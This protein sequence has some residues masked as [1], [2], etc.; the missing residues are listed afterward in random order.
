MSVALALLC[1]DGK[2]LSLMDQQF[3]VSEQNTVEPTSGQLWRTDKWVLSEDTIKE[4]LGKN[5]VLISKKG[6][7]TYLGGEIV[8]YYP[9]LKPVVV[10]EPEMSKRYGLVFRENKELQGLSIQNWNSRNP[11]RLNPTLNNGE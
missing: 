6:G 8:G 3:S 7:E 4:L 2:G 1:R 11:V 10:T 9:V 5:L